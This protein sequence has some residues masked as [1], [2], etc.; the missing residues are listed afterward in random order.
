MP[1]SDPGRGHSQRG[2]ALLGGLS[3]DP[4]AVIKTGE[5]DDV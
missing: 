1:R 4:K 5:S 2:K 3:G